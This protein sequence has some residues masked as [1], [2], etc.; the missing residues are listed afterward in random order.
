MKQG[1]NRVSCVGLDD[2]RWGGG[3]KRIVT[4]DPTFGGSLADILRG[5]RRERVEGREESP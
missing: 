3:V 5:W 2:M 4:T 1:E